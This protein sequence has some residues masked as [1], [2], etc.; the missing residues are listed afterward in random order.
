[1]PIRSPHCTPVWISGA[2]TS[3]SVARSRLRQVATA[4]ARWAPAIPLLLLIVRLLRNDLGANPAEEL[5]H[6]T[7]FT[8]LWL[9]IGSL[10]MT[11]LRRIT[12]IVGW[13]ALRRPLGLWAFWYAVLHLCC[14]LVFDHSF[15]LGEIV[16][17]IV[18][19]PYITV[20]FA[21]FL[22]LLLLAATSPARMM[23]RLGGRR[24]KRIH[25]L[26]YPAAILAA[27]HFLWS[28]KLD[29]TWPMIAAAALLAVLLGRLVPTGTGYAGPRISSE[30]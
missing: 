8:A 16:E 19:R 18:E 23:K 10:A 30:S 11:P 26:V 2:T 17:D 1:M 6:S 20:G 5:E 25:R 22:M 28:V 29:T 7:G 14:Y 12:G 15:M 13:T 4:A 24:W 9:L 3:A 21:A 27:V